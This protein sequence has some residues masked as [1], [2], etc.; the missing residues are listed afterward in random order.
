MSSSTKVVPVLHP[1]MHPK[2]A[3][4]SASSSIPSDEYIPLRIPKWLRR[5]VQTDKSYSETHSALK[6]NGLHTVCE[7]AKCPNRHECW[8]HGTATIMILGNICTRACRFCSILTGRPE[9]LDTNEPIRV[10][11][12]VEKMNLKHVVITSVTRDDLRDGGAEIFAQT[13]ERVKERMPKIT[14][15]VLTPDFW[16]RKENLYRVLD[17]GPI[18]FN[19]NI[20]TV[21][22]LQRSIRSGATYNRSMKILKLAAEHSNIKVKS[23]IM[24]GLGESKN[25]VMETIGD[26]FENGVRLLTIGQYMCPTKE[27]APID[28]FVEPDE[29]LEL[30]QLAYKVGFDAVASGPLVRSSYRADK[31]IKT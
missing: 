8:N 15:E 24:V 27:H 13:I 29:F 26:L 9:G 30:E 19:H 14:V 10:A 12:A 21:K 11:D 2:T 16:G 4:G 20:E 1:N 5:P 31:M 28:R 22:R 6:K 17:A 18:V 23:G 25:E 3:S 7:D